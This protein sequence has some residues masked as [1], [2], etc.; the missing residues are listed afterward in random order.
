M[1]RWSERLILAAGLCL[2]AANLAGCSARRSAAND[3]SSSQQPLDAW[4]TILQ[5]STG[6]VRPHVRVGVPYHSLVFHRED[7]R[8]RSGLEV[9]VLAWRDGQQVGGGVAQATVHVDEYPATR[10][11]TRL[12]VGAPLLIRG[13]Q[14]VDLEVLISVPATARLWKRKLSYQPRTLTVMPL[15]IAR[16]QTNL[17]VDPDGSALLSSAVDSVGFD[18][19]VRRHG[20]DWPTAGLDLVSEVTSPALENPRHRRSPVKAMPA[21]MDSL[22]LV[23]TWP[24]DRLPFG[25]NQVQMALEMMHE[26]ERIRLP[27]DPAL[28]LIN[29]RVSLS[30]DQAW[31]R[32]L[33]WLEGKADEATRDSLESIP[34]AGRELA[35]DQLWQHLASTDPRPV[36]QVRD[37]HL[38]RIITADDRFSD[39]KR[40]ALTDRGEVLIRHGEPARTEVYPD[41]RMPGAVWEAWLYPTVGKRYLFYDAHG[42]GDFRLR[43]TEDLPGGPAD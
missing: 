10:G 32:H 2:V 24:S 36:D 33:A 12:E 5:D 37:E 19:L 9:L 22:Q 14:P 41:D 34:V 30:N 20:N 27:R 23:Q 31:K 15:W 28:E 7:D 1:N 25:R 18:V 29:L 39:K 4:V 42:L 6:A 8:Y 21:D 35:W 11:H 43:Q 17:P 16:V 40:G 38:R 13:E 26:E 3:P